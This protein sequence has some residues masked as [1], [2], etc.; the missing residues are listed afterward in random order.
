MIL[1]KKKLQRKKIM[2]LEKSP[3]KFQAVFDQPNNSVTYKKVFRP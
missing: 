1:K 2:S 3:V